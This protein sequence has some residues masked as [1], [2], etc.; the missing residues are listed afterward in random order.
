MDTVSSTTYAADKALAFDNG[1]ATTSL[2]LAN[3]MLNA[4]Q[5]KD[6]EIKSLNESIHLNNK[7]IAELEA[8]KDVVKLITKNTK[9]G[10]DTSTY[11][12]GRHYTTTS[13]PVDVE[14]T[15]TTTVGKAVAKVEESL[16]EEYSKVVDAANSEIKE[17]RSEVN[18]LNENQEKTIITA[19]KD[20][21]IKLDLE[22]LQKEE[23]IDKLNY[24]IEK[25]DVAHTRELNEFN[26]RYA[27]MVLAK[28]TTI[29][30]LND[31]V[32]RLSSQN[33]YISLEKENEALRELLNKANKRVFNLKALMF[34]K[35]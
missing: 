24:I 12:W 19:I 29:T 18:A 35:W 25:N 10:T 15:E 26:S 11:M 22:L 28:D 2:Q 8:T 31:K 14:Y 3:N 1:A 7:K 27:R 34:W 16:R 32:E 6:N 9:P 30:E 21:N 4:I 20:A 13:V 17:L 5:L 23:H 33:E